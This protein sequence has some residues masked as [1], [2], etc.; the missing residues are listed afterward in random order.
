MSKFILAE[1]DKGE[2]F[3][4]NFIVHLV[5]CFF[6]GP[7]NRYCSK[8]ILKY[9][10]DVSQIASLDWYQFIVNELITSVRHYKEST[11]SKGKANNDL[12]APSFSPTLP[13]DK[14]DGEA[15][16]LGDTLVSDARIIIEKKE[17]REDVVLDQPKSIT[18]KDAS[19]LSYSLGLE[20]SQPD[21][22]NPVPQTTSVPNPSTIGVDEDDGIEDDEDG[23]PFRFP[24]RNTSQ[25]NHEH[26]IKKPAEKKPKED[27][28]FSSKKGEV[29][30]QSIKIKKSTMQ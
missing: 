16:I 30:K 17:H 14:P 15:E 7:K 23:A 25:V 2:S 5:N 3:K 11:A 9:V 10:K 21:N 1:K 26:S 8:S 6:S 24:L 4:R 22:Q 28:E 20:L 18:K 19:I 29:R 13:F 27:D 12:Y